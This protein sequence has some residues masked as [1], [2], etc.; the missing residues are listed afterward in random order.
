MNNLHVFKIICRNQP[1]KSHRNSIAISA[2]FS[3]DTYFSDI[4]RD[5]F[6]F[7]DRQMFAAT[8]RRMYASMYSPN[9]NDKLATDVRYKGTWTLFL[10][11]C[12]VHLVLPVTPLQV[13]IGSTVPWRHWWTVR[14]VYMAKSSF[15]HRSN[16]IRSLVFNRKKPS[17]PILILV[18]VLHGLMI[19]M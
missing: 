17:F 13:A 10:S 14:I 7:S 15:C 1:V 2:L 8:P 16:T 19:E 5:R 4:K 11:N 12:P 9:Q 6:I 3:V 18:A